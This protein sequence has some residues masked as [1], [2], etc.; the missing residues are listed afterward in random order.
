MTVSGYI[1]SSMMYVCFIHHIGHCAWL[2]LYVSIAIKGKV[3]S[4]LNGSVWAQWF[5]DSDLFPLLQSYCSFLCRHLRTSTRNYLLLCSQSLCLVKDE[6]NIQF[7]HC[8]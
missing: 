5:L 3:W 4:D 1:V 8:T 7:I 6:E 2:F